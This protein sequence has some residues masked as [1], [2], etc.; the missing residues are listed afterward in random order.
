M[1]YLELTNTTDHELRRIEILTVFLRNEEI[2]GGPSLSHIRFESLESIKSQEKAVI[3]HQT[4]GD[5]K[6]ASLEHDQI[7]RLKLVEGKARPY[8]LDI[9]WQDGHGKTRFQRI[10]VGH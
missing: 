6:P 8:V 5:G 2:I 1:P 4:W 10:P 3:R 7:E 9:S